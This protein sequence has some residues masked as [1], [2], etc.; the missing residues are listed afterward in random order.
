MFNL[1]ASNRFILYRK[2]TDMRKGFD[3]LSGLVNNQLKST[4]MSG[5]VFVFVN[6]YRD[7]IKLLHWESGGLTLYYK[8][9]EKGTLELP[10]S[11]DD[12]VEISWA[13]LVM[14][15]EG[16]SLEKVEKRTRFSATKSINL[17]V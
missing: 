9:L 11:K 15:I 14:I 13:D 10:K 16:I 12:K 17:V 6:R 8:R 3:G 7:K 5:E 2:P 4:I 1:S